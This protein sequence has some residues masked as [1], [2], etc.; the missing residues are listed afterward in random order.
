MTTFLDTGL[1]LG[2]RQVSQAVYHPA[3][4]RFGGFYVTFLADFSLEWLAGFFT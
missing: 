2:L 4:N 3:T 1:L